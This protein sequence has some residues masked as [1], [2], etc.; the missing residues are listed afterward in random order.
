ME[1][2]DLVRG[3]EQDLFKSKE[4]IKHTRDG[5]NDMHQQIAL[6]SMDIMKLSRRKK[7]L[8]IIRNILRDVYKR[9]FLYTV[10]IDQLI[11]H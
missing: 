5:L 9:F 2:M 11:L 8:E 1:G 10:E 3:V 4:I 7:R 6:S